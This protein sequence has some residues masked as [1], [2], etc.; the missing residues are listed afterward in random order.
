MRCVDNRQTGW[1][2]FN[3]SLTKLVLAL[4]LGPPFSGARITVHN[5]EVEGLRNQLIVF[6]HDAVAV[7]AK[8]H[9]SYHAGRVWNFLL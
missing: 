4:L 1:V 5:Y 7:F 9:E 2:M 8:G 3:S 6:E